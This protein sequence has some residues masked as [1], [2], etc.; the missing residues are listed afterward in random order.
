MTSSGRRWAEL[1][2]AHGS[3]LVSCGCRR[4]AKVALSVGGGKVEVRDSGRWREKKEER[5]ISMCRSCQYDKL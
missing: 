4:L 3:C 5:L 1:P 2:L